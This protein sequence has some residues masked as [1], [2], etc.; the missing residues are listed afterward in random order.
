MYPNEEAERYA[1]E[2]TAHDRDGWIFEAVPITVSLSRIV[3][4]EAR[5]PNGYEEIGY[6]GFGFAVNLHEVTA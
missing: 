6:I 4:L 1:Q 5:G 2:L 3:I